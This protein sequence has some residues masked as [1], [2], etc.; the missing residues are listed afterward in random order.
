MRERPIIFRG[1]MV[2]AILDGKKMQTRRVVKKIPTNFA[3]LSSRRNVDGSVEVDLY[4]KGTI[5]I[6]PNECPY[7]QPGDRL[8][9]RETF[10]TSA[11]GWIYKAD[12][13][14]L[15]SS[16]SLRWKP[17][18]HMPRLASRIWLGVTNVRVERLR[19][20]TEE[21]AIAEGVEY[22]EKV[23]AWKDYSRPEGCDV[24]SAES[25]F[26]TLWNSLHPKKDMWEDNPWVWV[27]Q[28][29]RID[30]IHH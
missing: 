8:W 19:G 2:R 30:E 11:K 7:G 21:D 1:K 27:I 14:D 22:Y 18:I 20:I 6:D 28:F 15:S 4:R 17:S 23:N 5:R 16:L 9:V 25:S 3:F 13:H 12:G 26:A 24:I 10:C 29:R